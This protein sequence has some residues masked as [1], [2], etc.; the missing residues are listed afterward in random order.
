MD[1]D[2]DDEIELGAAMEIDVAPDDG[3]EPCMVELFPFAKPI[4]YYK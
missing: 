2:E 3:G 1:I 4:K